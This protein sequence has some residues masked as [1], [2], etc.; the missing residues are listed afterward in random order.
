MANLKSQ[1]D[2]NYLFIAFLSGEGYTNVFA[3]TYVR[4]L[5]NEVLEI[6]LISKE[7]MCLR[8]D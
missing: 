2:V 5:E 6:L 3:S 1:V 4:Y 7:K 8:E